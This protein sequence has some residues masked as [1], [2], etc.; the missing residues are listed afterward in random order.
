V[1]LS[2]VRRFDTEGRFIRN[3]TEGS[4]SGEKIYA[5][6]DLVA[7]ASGNIY[8]TDS[9]RHKGKVCFLGK[10]GHQHVLM[11]DL[12]YPNGLVLSKDEQRL[13]VAESYKNRIILIDL[14][15]PGKCREACHV[16]A[17]LPQNKTG[18]YNLPDGLALDHQDNIW[19]AHYGMQAIQVLSPGGE[20]LCTVNTG[21]PLTSNLTFINKE[22]LLITGGFGEPG[23]GILLKYFTRD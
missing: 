18:Q 20:L 10:G 9:V 19:V 12:D 3:E 1:K 22:T 2:A 15:A 7:D 21:V 23:P 6:N 14:E 16:F 13:Y 5:P 8:F 11:G 17:T 4:C